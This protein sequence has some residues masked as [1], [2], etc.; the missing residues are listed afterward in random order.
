ML[1]VA[2]GE[3]RPDSPEQSEMAVYPLPI[4]DTHAESPYPTDSTGA[5]GEEPLPC[6][7]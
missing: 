5:Q 7:N 6:A 4:A 1:I 2:F 3:C